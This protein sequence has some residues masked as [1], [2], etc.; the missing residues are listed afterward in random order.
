MGS[1]RGAL[2]VSAGT[3][4]RNELADSINGNS[5]NQVRQF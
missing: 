3:K 1:G 4:A 5:E 2:G